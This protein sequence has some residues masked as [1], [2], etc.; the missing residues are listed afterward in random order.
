MAEKM[1]NF[2]ALLRVARAHLMVTAIVMMSLLQRMVMKNLIRE[3]KKLDDFLLSVNKSRVVQ[4]ISLDFH[5]A[6]KFVG[7]DE[8]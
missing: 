8:L 4:K 3:L 7:I 5:I 2:K 1:T 6:N